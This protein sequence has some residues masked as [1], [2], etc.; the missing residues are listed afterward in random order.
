MKYLLFISLL[1]LGLMMCSKKDKE[2]RVTFIRICNKKTDTVRCQT[3]YFQE[4]EP[5]EIDS[6]QLQDIS[7]RIYLN[8]EPNNP[9]IKY[10]EKDT[11][12]FV[13]D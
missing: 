5:Q 1:V 10:L 7:P 6:L 13:I 8:K 2:A 11:V 12:V 9:Y 4:L 3:Y